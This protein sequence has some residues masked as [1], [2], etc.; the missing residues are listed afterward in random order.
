MGDQ[1]FMMKSNVV[2]QPYAVSEDL[3]QSVDQKNLG[4][5][6]LHN[7]RTSVWISTNFTHSSL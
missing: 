3:V 7:L 5:M 6:A 1:M 2:S 4:E